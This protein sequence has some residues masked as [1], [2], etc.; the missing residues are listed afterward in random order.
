[1]FGTC[2]LGFGAF[3]IMKLYLSIVIPAY[4]EEQNIRQSL[5]KVF[6]FL[7][8]KDYP[9]EVI[10][11]DDGSTDKTVEIIE[12][13]FGE[14]TELKLIKNPHKGKGFTVRTGVLAA[15]GEYVLFADA[16]LATPI[17]EADRLLMWLKDHDFSVAIASREGFGAQR[18]K[19]P[20]YRHLMGRGFNFLVQLLV[21]SGI[22]DSQCGFKMFTREAAREIFSRLYIYGERVQKINRAYLGAFDV[23]V[24][25]LA[26]KL[27]YKIKEVPVTWRYVKTQRLDPLRDSIRMFWDI[28]GVR[29]GDLRGVY[30]RNPKS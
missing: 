1:M 11:V 28:V 25:F 15:K 7:N 23:E 26:R 12:E 20:Y 29:V 8:T 19:E 9:F 14:R 16:D 2:N 3:L 6:E 13:F 21:L 22:E 17:E 18:V 4:N 5:A 10:V 24:L 27:G 30:G